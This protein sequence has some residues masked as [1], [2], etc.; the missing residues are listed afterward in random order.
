M[1]L[2]DGCKVALADTTKLTILEVV[3]EGVGIDGTEILRQAHL[4]R[5]CRGKFIAKMKQTSIA[6]LESLMF[7][8][9]EGEETTTRKDF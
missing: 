2:C 7:P 1:I 8:I 3:A 4:C 5:V 9:P 6:Y